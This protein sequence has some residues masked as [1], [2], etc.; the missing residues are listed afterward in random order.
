MSRFWYFGCESKDKTGHYLFSTYSDGGTTRD[1]SHL[2][3]PTRQFD[4][5]FQ[6]VRQI[7]GTWRLLVIHGDGDLITIL[8]GWDRTADTRYGSN[9]SFIAHGNHSVDVMIEM[10]KKHFPEQWKRVAEGEQKF[11]LVDQ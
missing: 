9:A 11:N 6:P 8:A 2:G 7:P 4:G 1:D 10:A 5:T 3:F